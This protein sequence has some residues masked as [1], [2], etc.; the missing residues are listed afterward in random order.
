MPSLVCYVC[1]MYCISCIMRLPR[2]QMT[3]GLEQGVM[4]NAR[5]IGGE[6]WG[7]GKMKSVRDLCRNRGKG[8]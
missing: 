3:L 4:G 5:E 2:E 1:L 6:R 7:E 8:D